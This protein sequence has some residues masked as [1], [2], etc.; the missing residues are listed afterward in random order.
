MRMH[1]VYK[2]WKMS[3]MCVY[4]GRLC[5]DDLQFA[6]PPHNLSLAHR[7]PRLLRGDRIAAAV[8]H[9]GAQHFMI[10]AIQAFVYEK[11]ARQYL[12]QVRRQ[13][14]TN[15]HNTYNIP[16][17]NTKDPVVRSKIAATM[18]TKHYP[19]RKNGQYRKWPLRDRAA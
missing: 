5:T 15:A 6:T 4:V 2:I 19:R 16:M 9:E 7:L 10:S 14:L 18:R 17:V 8:R 13:L 11:D 1:V 12:A 3:T